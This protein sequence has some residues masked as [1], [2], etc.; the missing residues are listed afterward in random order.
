MLPGIYEFS[1]NQGHIIFLGI[2]YSVVIVVATTV[3][4]ALLRALRRSSSHDSAELARWHADFED[5]APMDRR[6]RHELAGEVASRTCE[7]FFSCR[8]CMEHQVFV[9][10]AEADPRPAANVDVPPMVAGFA[11]PADRLYHRGHTWVREEEDGTLTVGL[12]DL[13]MHLMGN[14]DRLELPEP[15][16]RLVT[17]GTAWH[18]TK[19]G[20]TVR[21]MSPIEGEVLAVGGESDDWTLKLRPEGDKADTRH[22][23]SVAEARPWMLREVERLHVALATDDVG[24]ALADG[25]VPV[26]DLA[27]AIPPQQ[28]EEVC[29]MFFLEP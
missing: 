12:D 8:E 18:A 15:G 4:I 3:V 16:T 10:L 22:L 23:L 19:N 5:L 17:N 6:C 28:F 7:N 24:A 21:V 29:G 14:P 13:G 11:L 27:S 1:W 9:A 26:D 20:V 2:F 25:G